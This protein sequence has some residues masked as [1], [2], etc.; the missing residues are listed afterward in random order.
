MPGKGRSRRSR[1]SGTNGND[2]GLSQKQRSWKRARRVEQNRGHSRHH[3]M[4]ESKHISMRGDNNSDDGGHGYNHSSSQSSSRY[5][6]RR[7]KNKAKFRHAAFGASNTNDVNEEIMKQLE[8]QRQQQRQQQQH[9]IHEEGSNAIRLIEDEHSC[10]SDS[11]KDE[12]VFS[13]ARKRQYPFQHVGFCSPHPLQ[14]L[15][16]PFATVP[17]GAYT[18]PSDRR[19]QAALLATHRFL[20]SAISIPSARELPSGYWSCL[21]QP[22]SNDF[23]ND[24]LF[25]LMHKPAYI[26]TFDVWQYNDR[27]PP[28]IISTGAVDLC[29]RDRH[30]SI[31]VPV[32]NMNVVTCRY[33]ALPSDLEK[34][35][36]HVI[37]FEAVARRNE[38]RDTIR[39]FEMNY[40]VPQYPEMEGRVGVSHPMVN[41]L[42][43]INSRRILL[44]PVYRLGQIPKLPLLALLDSEVAAYPS[45]P[46][47]VNHVPQSDGLCIEADYQGGIVCTGFRNGQVVVSDLEGNT[48]AA[49]GHVQKASVETFGS[50]HALLC[51]GEKQM[52]ARGS[53]GCVR[54]FDLRRLSSSASKMEKDTTVV[55]EYN[56]PIDISTERLTRKCRGLATDPTRSTVVAPV[57]DQDEVPTLA[58]WSIHTGEYV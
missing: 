54:L 25:G 16:W 57:V 27:E 21:S 5:H 3:D 18:C 24:D 12:P 35:N 39:S 44:A 20:R 32:G 43:Y 33:R 46:L 29:A 40:S 38:K 13:H 51:V 55:T 1:V 19:R 30:R 8:L 26:R 17:L 22:M 6:G 56:I 34:E 31:R 9:G 49:F 58:M 42:C 36:R 10:H 14:T 52:L 41:D 53:S 28:Q 11:P 47:N 23:L 4:Q 2:D 15:R 48:Q 37:H 50:V 7:Q 45:R